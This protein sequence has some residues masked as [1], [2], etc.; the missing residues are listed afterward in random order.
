I[1]ATLAKRLAEALDGF[2][3]GG[4]VW[5]VASYEFD[6]A[7]AGIFTDL[8]E[9]QAVARRVGGEYDT[10]GPFLQDR[11][12]GREPRFLIEC[13]DPPT[14]DWCPWYPPADTVLQLV[15]DVDSVRIEV[16]RGGDISIRRTFSPRRVDAL[17]FSLSALD[18]FVY[19]YYARLFGV[20]YAKG[21]RDSL[22]ARMQRSRVP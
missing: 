7:V 22:V 9:A 20:D 8:S 19:P 11:D 12:L 13:H 18:K 4:R 16:F 2:R 1:P 3:E 5:I 21:L 14:R 17:F 15:R 6:H 10:F